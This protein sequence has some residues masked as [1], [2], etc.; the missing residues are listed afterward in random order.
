M[1]GVR[2]ASKRHDMT[3]ISC[4]ETSHDVTGAI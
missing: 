3:M 2:D 4:S 1:K